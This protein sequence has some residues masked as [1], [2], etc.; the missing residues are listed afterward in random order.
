VFL[1]GNTVAAVICYIKRITATGLPMIA[2][3]CDII[4]VSL[5]KQW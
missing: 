2:N 3:L 5:D 4:L 1:A